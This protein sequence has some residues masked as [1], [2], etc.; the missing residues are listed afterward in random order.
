MLV[1]ISF[2]ESSSLLGTL[3]GTNNI[4]SI[5]DMRP[6]V[7]GNDD[8]GRGRVVCVTSR[9]NDTTEKETWG[10]SLDM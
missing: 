10:V 9:E 4:H 2:P 3:E 6:L 1:S 7:R 8:P 5:P